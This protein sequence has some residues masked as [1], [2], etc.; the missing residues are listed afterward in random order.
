M[1]CSSIHLIKRFF[2]LI[3]II[4]YLIFSKN[5]S[6]CLAQI[7]LFII[8]VKYSHFHP[9]IFLYH[10]LFHNF[11]LYSTELINYIHFMLIKE[12]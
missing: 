2:R 12:D 9:L 10:L 3:L 5:S 11:H 7:K 1:C 8:I 6:Y 4:N